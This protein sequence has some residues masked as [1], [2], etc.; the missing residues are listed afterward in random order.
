MVREI[1]CGAKMKSQIIFEQTEIRRQREY[2]KHTWKKLRLMILSLSVSK[3]SKVSAGSGNKSVFF[4]AFFF[5]GSLPSCG[6]EEGP[7]HC[8]WSPA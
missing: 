6:M 2:Q 1:H 7:T 5:S 3:L 4:A 8:T